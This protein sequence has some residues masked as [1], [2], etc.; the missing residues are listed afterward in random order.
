MQ[1][2]NKF[3]N[4]QTFSAKIFQHN[5][6]TLPRIAHNIKRNNEINHIKTFLSN[7][8]TKP[9]SKLLRALPSPLASVIVLSAVSKQDV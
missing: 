1:R 6:Q 8:F 2:Y 5:E 4:L 9:S 3:R 7:L